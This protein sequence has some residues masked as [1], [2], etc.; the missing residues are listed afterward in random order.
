MELLLD[1]ADELFPYSLDPRREALRILS[2]TDFLSSSIYFRS[3]LSTSLLCS[4]QLL[5]FLLFALVS[6]AVQRDFQVGQEGWMPLY[7]LH[8]R[9]CKERKELWDL[10]APC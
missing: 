7:V 9:H 10:R 1:G 3:S 5:Y 4:L 2:H 6:I 8:L